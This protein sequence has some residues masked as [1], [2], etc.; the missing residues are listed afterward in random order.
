M[1]ATVCNT[2]H[3]SHISLYLF[4]VSPKFL[5]FPV[6]GN[7]LTFPN[8]WVPYD[9]HDKINNSFF[10][11]HPRKIFESGEF[12]VVP[13]MIGLTKDEGLY[14]SNYFYKNHDK[15]REFWYVCIT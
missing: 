4:S 11:K 5:F 1:N 12:N 15:F 14:A 9:D 8:I 13:T 10:A 6:F 2:I 3:A 7:H